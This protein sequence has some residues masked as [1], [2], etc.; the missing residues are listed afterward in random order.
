MMLKTLLLQKDLHS[1]QCKQNTTEPCHVL[2]YYTAMRMYKLKCVFL[3]HN[4]VF[5]QSVAHSI[6]EPIRAEINF[7]F[8]TLFNILDQWNYGRKL[9]KKQPYAF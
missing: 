5:D 1:L 6:L 4:A 2:D 9:E 3:M 7:A 8:T